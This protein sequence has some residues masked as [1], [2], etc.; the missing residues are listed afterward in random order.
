MDKYV[1]FNVSRDVAETLISATSISNQ[2]LEPEVST[3]DVLIASFT[4]PGTRIFEFLEEK[5]DENYLNPEALVIAIM[6]IKEAYEKIFGESYDTFINLKK[7]ISKPVKIKLKDD[8]NKEMMEITT[9]NLDYSVYL[10]YT[11]ILENALVMADKM[12]KEMG[13]QSIQ[14]DTL[15]YCMLMN[16]ESRANMLLK[17]YFKT[18]GLMKYLESGL[19]IENIIQ[20]KLD[21]L[22]KD[23]KP[24]ITNLNIKFSNNSKCDILGRD[25]EIFQVWNIIS[26]K[27][28]RNAVLIG[29]PGVGKTAIVE[30]ITYSIL[31]KT[32]P[33]EF[34]NYTVYSLN[35]NSMVAGTK[36]RGEFEQKTQKLIEFI[37]K[38]DNVIIFLDEIHHLLG[39]GSAKGS[40]PDLSG[41]LKPLLARDNVV[42]IGATT[43][44]EYEKIFSKDGALSRRF[45]TVVVKEPKFNEVIPMIKGR[46]KS[47]S[48][49]HKVKVSNAMLNNVLICAASF[50]N[51]SNP[52]RTIDLL[53]KS[54]AVAKMF[55]DTQL[56]MNHIK[57]V[58]MKYFEKY[59]KIK[60]DKKMS[61]AYH[62]A[63]HFAAWYL[64]KTKC[65]QDCVLISIIPAYHWLGVNILEPD[66]TQNYSADITFIKEKIS[67]FLAR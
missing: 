4:F 65:N 23:L 1:N 15:I 60:D 66:D 2:L 61:T 24:F 49:Y 64:S 54:M 6:G 57:K 38:T 26:K 63:G 55:G 42:F 22:P 13:R 59:E 33:K 36:Y 45:E 7:E 51:I 34:E 58:Y 62:E 29:N 40:G 56:S 27:T 17:Y 46:I 52:D 16:K 20:N 53:D 44:D 9:F 41:S 8:N 31:N 14:L 48:D 50:S 3:L 18:P 12:D 67:M 47:L 30:A 5:N 43:T 32:C 35:L 28:K 25:D 39:A 10:T 19:T 11:S 21:N 37:E